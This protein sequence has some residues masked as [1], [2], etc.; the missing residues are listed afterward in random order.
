MHTD[1]E[2]TGI[3]EAATGH[4]LVV[5][6]HAGNRLLL[7]DLLEAEGHEV[8]EAAD[9]ASALASVAERQ[10]DLILL[11]VQMP[12]MDGFE[13]CR[14]LKASPA[15]AAVPVLLVTA[16]SAREDRL[17]GIRAGANDFV[18]KPID[19]ADLMLRARNAIQARRLHAR[20]EAQ[21]RDLSEME[22]LRDSLVHMVAHDLRSPLAGVH[23]ILEMLQMDAQDLPAESAAFLNDALRLTRRAADMIGDLLDVSRLEAGRL[24]VA[25][26]PLDL[27]GLADQAT[28]AMYPGSVRLTYRPPPAAVEVVGDAKLLFRV[29]TN[30]LDN[31]IKF[32]PKGGAVRVSVEHDARGAVF[33]VTDEGPG[34]PVEAREVI[35]DKFAQVEGVSQPRPS[36]GLGL[37]FCKLV[38]DA[39]QGAC[40]VDDAPGGGSKFWFALP[41]SAPAAAMN[42]SGT[43]RKD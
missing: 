8:V 19:S 40:G 27:G 1:P 33:V 31:A 26:D 20:V 30:L 38:I 43:P 39:H 7:R 35:F 5:D 12:G 6:D 23:A 24:P 11:D 15:T 21:Y 25:R 28:R 4:V 9:G 37:T 36:S 29:V 34:V 14:R 41:Q 42:W 10:P 18:I 32:T 22:Q 2:E 16:L 3:N 17:E 13:V